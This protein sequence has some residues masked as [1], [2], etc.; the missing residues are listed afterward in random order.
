VRLLF[1]VRHISDGRQI[2]EILGF[3]WEEGEEQLGCVLS[4]NY[5][6]VDGSVRLTVEQAVQYLE[7]FACPATKAI[8]AAYVAGKVPDHLGMAARVLGSRGGSI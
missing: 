1:P 7:T 6:G 4:G 8:V 2:R 3:A 5:R